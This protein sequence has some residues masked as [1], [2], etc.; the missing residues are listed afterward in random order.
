MKSYK[1]E[2]QNFSI[3]SL[4]SSNQRRDSVCVFFIFSVKLSFEGIG[5]S[6]IYSSL[7]LTV[8]VDWMAAASLC[9][10]DGGLHGTIM[11]ADIKI[12]LLTRRSEKI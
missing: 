2:T 7:S 1:C 4:V 5:N 10:S 8:T 6:F 12:L 11:F 9:C 3:S